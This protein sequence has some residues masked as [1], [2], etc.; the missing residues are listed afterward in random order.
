MVATLNDL[1]VFQND[2]GIGV[3]DRGKTVSDHEGRSAL[4]Q[5][6]HA[7]LD[8]LLRMRVDGAGR[9]IQDHD[10]RIGYRTAGD[11]Q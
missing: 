10:R 11:V 5:F 6:I 7:L 2:D 1:A 3:T 9:F 8:Q 4:H